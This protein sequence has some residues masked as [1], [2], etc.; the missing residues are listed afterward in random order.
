MTLL[1]YHSKYVVQ[2]ST[3]ISTTS[4]TL[5]DDSYASQTFSLDSTKTVLAIYVAN[6]TVAAADSNSLTNAISIDGTDHST[7]NQ[8]GAVSDGLA[9]LSRNTCFWIGSLNAGTHTIKG[10][11]AATLPGGTISVRNRTLLI[12]IFN[13]NEFTFVENNTQQS[14]TSAT[15]VDDSYATATF[16]PTG[17]CKALILYAANTAFYSS[18][19]IS[20][21][22]ICI[23]VGSTDYTACEAHQSPIYFDS[24]N[25]LCTAYALPLTATSTTVKGRFACVEYGT[26]TVVTI[27]KH[28]LGVLLLD[29]STTVDLSSSTTQVSNSSTTL[30][31]DTQATI[32]RSASGELLVLAQATQKLDTSGSTDGNIYGISIDSTDVAHTRFAPSQQGFPFSG[33]VTYAQTVTSGSHTIYGRFAANVSGQTAIIDTR[34]LI[35]LW[36]STSTPPTTLECASTMIGSG[37]L[38]TTAT[39]IESAQTLS[40]ASTISGSGNLTANNILYKFL[41][42]ILS[43]SGSSTSQARIYKLITSTVSGSGSSTANNILLTFLQLASSLSGSGSSTANIIEFERLASSVSGSGTQTGNA[44]LQKQISSSVSSSGSESANII[45]F[46]LL[47]SS[48]TGSGSQ[49]GNSSL[50]KSVSSTISGSGSETATAFVYNLINSVVSGSGTQTGNGILYQFL[51]SI[52]SGAGDETANITVL[53][54]GAGVECSSTMIGSGSQSASSSV[55]DFVSSNISGSGT[56]TGN[57]KLNKIIVSVLSGSGSQSSSAVVSAYLSSSV[58]GSGSQTANDILY[59]F[60]SSIISGSSEQSA[61]A[62]VLNYGSGVECY[63]SVAGS[64]SQSANPLLYNYINSTVSGAGSETG[65]ANLQKKIASS[66]SGSGSQ[67]SRA[68]LQKMI[69]S[70][71]EGNGEY[72]SSV[73]TYEQL[74]SV[75]SGSGSSSANP[76]LTNYISSTVSG[77]GTQTASASLQEIISSILEG[78]G[79]YSADAT[80]IIIT[81]EDFKY[82]LTVVLNAKTRT[83]T[84]IQNRRTVTFN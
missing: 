42:S 26:H 36:F 74:S 18:E 29:D 51:S 83:A 32:T 76:T 73:L 23:R 10:R 21:K 13:G 9:G 59:K 77:S 52:L 1:T 55:F 11:F 62:V 39:V 14:T 75:L 53:N 56:Q 71:I 69:Q 19:D 84:I 5:Q 38:S 54:F 15:Y 46:E 30:A 70:I 48:V 24:G 80:I 17:A 61:N 40:C 4:T 72:T 7:A 37:S 50:Q 82:P 60:I 3:A 8:A 63:S 66:V 65:N 79:E 47:N 58:S 16:T 2:S 41:S 78:S 33:F 31:N 27:D 6:N 81:H 49:S 20:G 28:V 35:A 44:N 57:A 22:K 67:T 25:S 43:G 45:I 12:Y 34:I 68:T 64:G